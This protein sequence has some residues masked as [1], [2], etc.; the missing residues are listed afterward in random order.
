MSIAPFKTD[1]ELLTFARK[2]FANRVQTFKKDIAICLTP[3]EREEHAYFPALIIC[4]AFVDLLSGL[5][6]GT[7][8]NQKL[9]ELKA[10]ASKFMKPDYTPQ[11][12]D[13]LY[14][15][16]RHKVAHL[17]YPYVVFD[18]WTN[19]KFR[20]QPRRFVT[21]TIN[22]TEQR[23]AI[24]ITKYPTPCQLTQTPTPWPVS[25]DCRIEVN[26]RGVAIDIVWS[27]EGYLQHLQSDQEARERFA[28]CMKDYFPSDQ[29]R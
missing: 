10:Y 19:K 29:C 1:Q 5:H 4:I 15:F 20:D 25:Y 17:A 13:I 23:P 11:G 16:L 14:E 3:N 7:L 27:I 6:A 8:H 24:A 9:E 2:F 26:V 21:W 12:L 22:E 18:T 28:K